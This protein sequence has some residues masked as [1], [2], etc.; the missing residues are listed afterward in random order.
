MGVVTV[1]ARACRGVHLRSNKPPPPKFPQKFRGTY[2][3]ASAFAE[4]AEEEAA[5]RVPPRTAALII[6]CAAS[7]QAFVAPPANGGHPTALP[8]VPFICSGSWPRKN[9]EAKK[10]LRKSYPAQAAVG[11]PRELPPDVIE[12][13]S[14]KK[15]LANF[16]PY[17]FLRSQ[18]P[19]PPWAS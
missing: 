5:S 10:T 14:R 16:R 8:G 7:R 18:D 1:T 4:L 11:S 12:S 19:K 6:A 9:A 13:R 17:T 2:C 3:Q 15:I